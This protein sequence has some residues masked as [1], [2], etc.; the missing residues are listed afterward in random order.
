MPTLE[1][2]LASTELTD[3]V[4]IALPNGAK[5]TVGQLREYQRTQRDAATK[6]QTEYAAKQKA[7][8]EA[9]AKAERLATDSLALWEE[10]NKVRGEGGRA[11]AGGEGG[12][13]HTGDIDWE[14]DPVY[15]P[16]HQRLSKDLAPISEIQAE[17]KKLQSAL[18]AGFKFVTDDYQ[19]RR[20]NA[21]P[22]DQRPK[23]KTWRDYLE[24]AK[25]QNLK[26][27]YG[28]DD[29]VAAWERSTADE[30]RAAEIK[31]AEERGRKRAEEEA[32]AAGLPRPG[33]TPRVPASAQG[34]TPKFKD[35]TEALAAA[36]N[37]PE[38]LRIA[39]G[40]V[41]Q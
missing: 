8:D 36:Q 40:E 37:D 7:A 24:T 26:D 39:N 6:A 12:G 17:I 16:V 15:R 30:R 29:P 41:Q 21:I 4:E 35:L 31:A 11:V 38:I 19:E 34:G 9:R 2:L 32:R 18:A 28:L 33:S 10:A 14:N 20:W 23:D 1:E 27:P 25:Q 22:K 5:V 3:A 13:N